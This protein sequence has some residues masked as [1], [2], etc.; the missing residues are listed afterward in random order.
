DLLKWN[1]NFARPVV[2]DAAFVAEQQRAGHFNDGRAHG[3]AFGL[4][5]G[6]YKGLRE[7]SH[8]G[9]TAGYNAFLTR[10]PDQQV[11]V[12]VLC[13]A[14][15][16]N[17]TQ[18]AHRVAEVY[19]GDRVTAVK[20]TPSYTLT[21]ADVTRL[22]GLYRNLATGAPASIARGGDFGLRLGE[23]GPSLVPEGALALWAPAEE[24]L[25][26]DGNG[27]VTTVDPFGTINRLE[28]VAPANPT[29][30]E[31]QAYAGVY[32]SDEA[33]TV[34]TAKVEGDRLVLLQRPDRRV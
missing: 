28:R 21:P 22:S 13:N 34:L 25:T 23:N 9:S 16:A 19:L 31:L 27:G 32:E 24:R 14:T 1:E 12:A 17:A 5:V 8:S 30:V 33:E 11:S 10:F 2:G 26:F 18:F 4:F 6:A 29:P 20:A 15:S 7:V 3:Y